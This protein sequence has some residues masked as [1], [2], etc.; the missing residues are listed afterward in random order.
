MPKASS[1]DGLITPDECRA[2]L[3]SG[4]NFKNIAEGHLQGRVTHGALK[5]WAQRNCI[6]ARAELDVEAL[7]EYIRD[8]K[9][10]NLGYR[11]TRM[12]VAGKFGVRVPQRTIQAINRE[13]DPRG[14]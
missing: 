9:E 6:R 4:Y 12:V 7:T 13:V 10:R 1:L 8:E 14:I 5:K 2:L 3:E 11:A